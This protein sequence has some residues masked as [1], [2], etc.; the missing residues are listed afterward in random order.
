MT[1]KCA[2]VHPKRKVIKTTVESACLLLTL[3]RGSSLII[4]SQTKV[5]KTLVTSKRT[6]FNTPLVLTNVH[7]LF[8][9]KRQG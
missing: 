1:S 5:V 8:N 3:L 7:F 4:L 6:A 9:P 2:S